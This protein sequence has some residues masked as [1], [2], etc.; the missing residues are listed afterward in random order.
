MHHCTIGSLLA[1]LAL[2]VSLAP[3]AGG[4]PNQKALT[5]AIVT[6]S[7]VFGDIQ[8]NLTHFEQLIAEAAAAGA[9]LVCFPELALV[10]YS[11][12]PEILKSAEP[13][14]G[15]ATDRLAQI[16]KRHNVYI[17]A[18]MAERDG[19]RRHIAQILVGPA[20][21]LGKYRK[22]FPTGTE[23]ACGFVPGQ[24]Y[25]TW[26]IEGFRFGI[27]ICAD[28][29]QEQTILAMKA[30][31]VEVIHHPH[32]NYV[33]SLGRDAEEWTRSKLVYI[34]PRALT[35]RAHISVNNSAAEIAEPSGTRQFSSGAL[36]ID[37]LGQ[38]VRRTEQHDRAERMIVVTLAHPLSLIPPGELRLLAA[39][40]PDLRERVERNARAQ[41]V[42]A[43][44]LAG[45]SLAGWTTLTGS[46]VTKGW[47]ASG[48]EIW[49]NRESGRGGHI[50]T[51]E[52]FGDFDLTFEWKIAP[53]GN[54]GLKYRVRTY[55]DQ[56]LGCEY[57]ICDEPEGRSLSQRSAGALYDLY[58]PSPERLLKPAGEWN[59]A[60]IVVSG[61]KIEHWLNG[62][63]IV[64]ANVGD[65]EWKKRVA[66]SKFSDVP[67]F[68]QN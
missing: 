30:A 22:C 29:R 57:Q 8:A 54:S 38:V 6:S 67:D 28:G 23:Q 58:E 3:A 26:D 18:G 14:P 12:H 42:A 7:S 31:G 56:A 43:A 17:S 35:A 37:S 51:K 55:G 39:R 15:P 66:A 25:P 44:P 11:T 46:Q 64:S 19:E 1:A 10:G 61:Q 4:E 20:G 48:G 27:V 32:G 53:R 36:V 16:A 21:Y 59:Q 41:D 63:L 5:V 60:R 62:R 33:G 50:I 34:A 40:D 68:G 45:Q 47:Q 13:I 49:L 65:E 9:R 24:E 2:V 52:E